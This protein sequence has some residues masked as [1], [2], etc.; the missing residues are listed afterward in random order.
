MF[1]YLGDRHQL[2]PTCTDKQ[3]E[4]S[5]AGTYLSAQETHLRAWTAEAHA[6]A[7]SKPLELKAPASI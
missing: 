1:T 6:P 7:F 2:V 5:P 4:D 3:A